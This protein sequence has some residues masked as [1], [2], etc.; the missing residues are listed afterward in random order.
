MFSVVGTG[1][2][3]VENDKW[4][5]PWTKGPLKESLPRWN[6]PWMSLYVPWT[7]ALWR[8]GPDFDYQWVGTATTWKA[9]CTLGQNEFDLF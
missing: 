9:Y 8:M 5:V 7:K 4:Y 1:G 2:I 6:A 3:T